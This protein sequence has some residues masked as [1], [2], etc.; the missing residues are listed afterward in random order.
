M[1]MTLIKRAD[2][3]GVECDFYEAGEEKDVWLTREQIGQAL[4]YQHPRDSIR[5][6]HE[7]NLERLSKFSV[8]VKLTSTDGKAYNT[9]LYSPKGVYEICRWSRQP[10]ADAFM[11][12]VWEQVDR[13]A[14][15]APPSRTSRSS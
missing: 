14:T 8:T 1:D 9:Y 7:R 3:G 10:K 11:D 15:P 2:F 4:E 13:H 12:W 5:K 6:I